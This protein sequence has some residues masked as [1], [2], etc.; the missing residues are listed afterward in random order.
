MKSSTLKKSLVIVLILGIFSVFLPELKVSAASILVETNADEITA[1]GL[2]SLREAILNA[3]EK[4]KLHDDCEAGTGIDTI[5]FDTGV[6]N[7]ILGSALPQIKENLTIN[8]AGVVT[9]SGGN[10]VT[11]FKVHTQA[12]LTLFQVTVINGYTTASGGGINSNGTLIVQESHF[13]NN[14]ALLGG[15][16]YTGKSTTI[17]NSTFVNNR[18]DAGGAVA[19]STA[20][21]ANLTNLTFFNNQATNGAGAGGGALLIS[22]GTVTLTNL[23]LAGNSSAS[24]GGG[25]SQTGG[26]ITLKNTIVS[27]STGGNCSGAITDD[28][29]NLV[30]GDNSCPG[31]VID[32]VL[33]A[34]TN[35]GGQTQTMALGANSGAVN[36][37][38]SANCPTKDQRGVYRR[39]GYCDAGAY[40]AQ[41]TALSAYSGTPQ[42]GISG[43]P[44][45][46]ALVAVVYDGYDNQLG[47]I[48]LEF[49]A[50]S[51]G[52]S[53]TL[54]NTQV[55]TGIDGTAS[56]LATANTTTGT[57]KVTVS[58]GSLT[59]ADFTLTNTEVAV[60]SITR[61]G[62]N[63]TNAASINFTVTFNV[64][65]NGV[66]MNDFS[67]TVGGAVTDAS[68]SG[69]VGS[70]ASYSVSVNTG[71][72]DGTIR[73]DLIDDDSI[74]D[75]IYDLKL[76]GTGEGNGNFST[77]EVYLMDKT[78]PITTI[79]SGPV[80]LT[81]S[82][83]ATFQFSAAETASGFECSLDNG[84]FTACA[85]PKDYT[86]LL[87]GTHTFTV[88]ATDLAGNQGF[89]AED[90]N[91]VV[92]TT[93][94]T[95][96][97][98]LLPEF[99]PASFTVSWTGADANSGVKSFDVEF[100]L[101]GGNWT[102]WL[103]DTVDLS[104]VF[105]GTS[106]HSYKF[107]V[108]AV[109]NVGNIGDWSVEVETET[110]NK[111]YL[112]FISR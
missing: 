88:R 94:P 69:V 5:T 8:G 30:W 72:G 96:V 29:G 73:L 4:G 81:T 36:L 95:A 77:G 105:N 112:P 56:V 104:A 1:N 13:E 67:V 35:N 38:L 65:V 15:G 7:I 55:I 61:A 68:I 14:N 9:V 21:P 79:D 66:D 60:S 57:Y 33:Q 19:V 17:E 34:L 50:P 76:G 63:P 23:T 91:W 108:R 20:G 52:A 75:Q 47:G 59:P 25:I 22:D 41:P 78:S 92:D 48:S 109:D 53:A 12:T 46:E 70:G 87:D 39:S 83:N 27:G 71:S 18:A 37:A 62:S 93:K 58:S 98:A 99:S 106:N 111:I 97:L 44:F 86:N 84:G 101:D 64:P 43:Y 16:I 110:K 107:R 28:G 6:E 102:A 49:S 10:T 85:S 45:N 51:S 90:Y 103:T 82:P 3:N 2:C 80:S 40:E 31:T 89:P 26:T 100:Q 24:N 11:V 32:P 74:T 54:N 42:Y